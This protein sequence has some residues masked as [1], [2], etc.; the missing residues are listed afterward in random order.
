VTSPRE[1]WWW[2]AAVLAAACTACVQPV[3]PARTADDYEHKAKD[4]AETV[5]SSVRTAALAVDVATRDRAFPP[6]VSVLLSNAEDDAGGAASKFASVQ[7]PGAWSD[8]L[9][10]E[11]G[12]L[13][14]E[15][16]DALAAARIAARRVDDDALTAQAEPLDRI[17]GELDAFI[18][19]IADHG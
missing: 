13:L 9:R 10:A 18:T 3:G 6:Y 1:K 5:L 2:P 19:D 12:D 15:A 17:A 4:T 7:P 16:E 11:L 8:R 14:D